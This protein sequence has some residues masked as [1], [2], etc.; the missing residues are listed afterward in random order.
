M[1]KT[2]TP[3]FSLA[4]VGS[5]A[6]SLTTQKG[7]AATVVRGRPVPSDPLTLAQQYQRWDYIDQSYIWRSLSSADKLTQER[8]ARPLHMTGFAYWLGTRLNALPDIAGRWRLDILAGGITP[9][10]SKNA[11]PGT[12]YGA[13]LSE[14][15]IDNSF[16]FDGN[17]DYI[18][19]DNPP[20]LQIP[21]ILTISLWVRALPPTLTIHYPLSKT[22]GWA[23]NLSGT[24]ARFTNHI[25]FWMNQ[26]VGLRWFDA[27]PPS[28]I[29]TWCH[30]LFTYS[31]PNATLY[32]NGSSQGTLSDFS[33]D[34]LTAADLNIGRRNDDVWYFPG[35]ID[36]VGIYNRI[37][38]QA[39][40]TRHSLRRYP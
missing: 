6:S 8:L 2:K 12:V 9:D 7:L 14:G 10:N 32:V 33:D 5:V 24:D 16:S 11:N 27:F 20:P 15:R 25:G 23:L 18:N 38:D 21:D 26:T 4:S 39:E 31:K 36:H 35:L 40:I 34:I 22:P 28:L 30:I 17:D 3:F 37:F 1:S 29:N 13:S 19:C